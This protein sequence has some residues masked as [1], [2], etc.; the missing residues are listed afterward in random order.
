VILGRG[1]PFILAPDRALRVLVTAPLDARIARATR[2]GGVSPEEA[3]AALAHEEAERRQFLG[4]HFHVDPD[5]ARLYD[6]VV[7][8][9]TLGVDDAAAV[10][11]EALR[12]RFGAAAS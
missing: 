12:R 5:D 10:V 6:L 1:A 4:F 3:R 7:N 9:A 11:V 2:A 8:T